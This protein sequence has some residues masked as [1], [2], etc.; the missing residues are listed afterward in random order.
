MRNHIVLISMLVLWA[1]AA[2][3]AI[4][5]D[6]VG[7]DVLGSKVNNSTVVSYSG[8]PIDV[9]II[10]STASNI[11]IGYP[12]EEIDT[13]CINCGVCDSC[14]RPKF[15]TTPWDDFKR[16]LCYPWSSYIPTRYNKDF[17]NSFKGYSANSANT[18]YAITMG[19]GRA[20]Y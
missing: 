19:Q 8:T 11:Q 10:G 3:G 9:D 20:I 2:Y 14:G 13:D 6:S 12:E 7:M 1:S 17:I 5:G 15:Y 4:E 18:S 16:P